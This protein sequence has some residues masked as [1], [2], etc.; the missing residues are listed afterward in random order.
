M[1]GG[2]NWLADASTREGL[3]QRFGR[4]STLQLALRLER[5]ACPPA[6]LL[7]LLGVHLRHIHEVVAGPHGEGLGRVGLVEPVVEVN[8]E[9]LRGT[10]SQVG[11]CKRTR[12]IA[13]SCRRPG[14]CLIRRTAA[15]ST[16]P[17]CAVVPF[18]YSADR[19]PDK[20][21]I[22]WARTLMWTFL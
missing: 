19:I 6:R 9:L 8:R 2:I 5:H 3:F 20:C 12:C 22:L 1:C 13:G 10:L 16:A 7:E 17:T 15:S 11:E 14:W 4:A 21:I 18:A